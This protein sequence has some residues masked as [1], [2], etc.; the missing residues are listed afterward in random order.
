MNRRVRL[1]L[2]LALLWP[3]AVAD[4]ATLKTLY[5]FCAQPGCA[6]GNSPAAGVVIDAAGNLYGTTAQGGVVDSA[7]TAGRG[8]VFRLA[9]DGT[10]TVLH[11]F[12]PQ[13][14][15]SQDG[16]GSQS[17]LILDPAGT[18]YGATRYGGA[19]AGLT[20]AGTVFALSPKGG[21]RVLY[22]FCSQPHCADGYSPTGLVRGRDGALFGA[23]QLAQSDITGGVIFRL[24][25][26]GEFSVLYAF[27]YPL[28]PSAALVAD[29]AGTLYGALSPLQAVGPD[30]GS[31]F[32]LDPAH[33]APRTLHNFCAEPG[34]ADGFAPRELIAAADGALYGA[35]AMGGNGS[36]GQGGT[37]FRLKRDPA[38]GGWDF[39]VLH[40]FCRQPQC[41]D[42]AGPAGLALDGAGNL[43][44]VA[45]A[46]PNDAGLV[47][48]IAP[49]RSYTRLYAFCSQ[50]QCSD[51]M[52]P[53]G[54]LILDAAGN[55]YGVAGGGGANG[56]GT[57][58]ELTP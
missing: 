17:A 20:E 48:R 34:C 45:A 21:E 39:T 54:P 57:V 32:A 53:Y 40:G 51:G 23:T 31:L 50:P 14:P 58:F 27:P 36:H 1:L 11:V 10:L 13:F 25:P 8:T 19:T 49:D 2:A 29:A 38:K 33:P 12:P 6:V 4:A 16:A 9:P 28:H 22:D 30:W 41:A 42:G 43:Y 55:L 7:G 46:G 3:A 35:T 44:G 18:L 24:A 15:P 37:V 26:R 5:S 47:F 56:G 52:A